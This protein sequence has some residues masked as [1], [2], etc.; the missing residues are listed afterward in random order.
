MLVPV[1]VLHCPQCCGSLIF[2][3]TSNLLQCTVCPL[4]YPLTTGV[5]SLV[6]AESVAQSI[7]TDAEFEQL[8]NEAV[9]APFTGW[10]FTWL[11]AR[12]TTTPQQLGIDYERRARELLSTSSAVLDHGTG[13]GERLTRLA[14]PVGTIATESYRRMLP[15]RKSAWLR[16]ACRCCTLTP[17]RMIPAGRR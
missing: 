12:C 11:G 1:S 5:P 2:N 17:R 10:D 6:I 14:P 4:E 7:D 8:V 15:S 13:G 3:S 9:A 16:L